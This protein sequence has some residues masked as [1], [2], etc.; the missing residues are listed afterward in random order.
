[1]M[2]YEEVYNQIETQVY[3]YLRD[4]DM[5]SVVIG[6]SGG[7]DSAVNT[8]ILRRV[9][10]KLGISLIGRYIHIEGNKMAERNRADAIGSLFCDDFKL[11]NL[12]DEYVML[13]NKFEKIEI[14]DSKSDLVTFKE[15]VMYGN[16]KARIRMIYLYYLAQKNYGLVIDNDNK[17][18]NLLGYW[19]IGGDIG[20]LTPLYSLFKTEVKGLAKWMSEHFYN[21][22]CPEKLAI[23][24]CINAEP[25]AGLGVTES[26]VEEFG[27]ES[28]EVVDDILSLLSK[29]YKK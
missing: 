8:V 22:N 23:M 14:G 2:N 9:C 3:E 16:I 11:V 20:D 4:A 15:R 7:L 6:V 1:M 21:D 18:E 19:T 12:T 13:R 5:K 27:V 26:D 25:T 24:N 10:D 17:S 29:E 28:Y